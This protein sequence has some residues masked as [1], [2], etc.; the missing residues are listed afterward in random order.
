L[1]VLAE[2]LKGEADAVYLK[3]AVRAALEE[4]AS[5]ENAYAE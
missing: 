5:D 4:A 1:A 3:P 2:A